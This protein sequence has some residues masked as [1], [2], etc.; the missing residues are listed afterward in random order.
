MFSHVL[1]TD[2]E[3][4]LERFHVL[5]KNFTQHFHEWADSHQGILLRKIIVKI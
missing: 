4:G 5:S 1:E 3:R 2:N